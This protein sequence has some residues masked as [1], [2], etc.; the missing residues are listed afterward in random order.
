[1]LSAS[2]ERERERERGEENRTKVGIYDHQTSM[3]TCTN[4]LSCRCNIPNLFTGYRPLPENFV[5]ISSFLTNGLCLVHFRSHHLCFRSCPSKKCESGRSVFF[6]P[7]PPVFTPKLR[8]N[9]AQKQNEKMTASSTIPLCKYFK[10]WS[11]CCHLLGKN[12]RTHFHLLGKNI[13]VEYVGVTTIY[14]V[15]ETRSH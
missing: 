3:L 7:L 9:M 4:T 15:E 10:S 1:M 11:K 14:K 8:P 6:W 2:A 13:G 12:K 5:L